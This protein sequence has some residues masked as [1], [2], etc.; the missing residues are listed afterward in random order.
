MLYFPL[1]IL[2][3]VFYFIC[4]EDGHL[5]PAE[6]LDLSQLSAVEFRVQGGPDHG[7]CFS[8]QVNNGGYWGHEARGNGYYIHSVKC[9]RGAKPKPG[10]IRISVVYS[11]VSNPP[12]ARDD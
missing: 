8:I 9:P 11:L 4:G 7:R 6:G 3:V 1:F 5:T 10:T 12:A 2:T